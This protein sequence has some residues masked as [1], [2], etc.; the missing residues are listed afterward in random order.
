MI[1]AG[2][3]AT[4]FERT[5]DAVVFAIPFTTL[6]KVDLGGLDLP[7]W[8]TFAIANLQYGTNAKLLVGFD[9]PFWRALGNGDCYVSG[10]PNLQNTW[11]TNWSRSG[12]A[13]AILTDYTGGRRGE[14]LGA[15]T[16][17]TQT[18]T[19][20]A[21]LEP[22]F[23][24]TLANATKVD[25]AY[26]ADL[27]H[28]PSQPLW[29]GSYTCNQPGY[30]TTIAGN[31]GKPSATCSLPASTP[32]VSIRF[33]ASWRGRR[34]P[35]SAPPPPSRPSSDGPVH[36]ALRRGKLSRLGRDRDPSRAGSRPRLR[37]SDVAT[38]RERCR[39]RDRRS[40]RS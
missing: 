32:T 38:R 36:P 17:D 18:A 39:W 30:F 1:Q 15:G 34:S 21:D 7:D 2:G 23:P 8:K 10:A 4:T 40:R 11:E 16:V 25:G 3:G 20:L 33:K 12:D 27:L 6:R 19:L 13:G 31:E 22:V 37:S 14:R 35:V 9:Q 26:R 24:G 28:W 29:E 5:F